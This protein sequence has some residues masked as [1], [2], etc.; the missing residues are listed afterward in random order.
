MEKNLFELLICAAK[1][2]PER[3]AYAA[4]ELTLT[5]RDLYEK[6]LSAAARI[7]GDAAVGKAVAIVMDARSAL[8][9]PV[10]MGT[11]AAGC[12]Y[13]PLDPALPEER[14][15]LI[16]E[17]LEPAVVIAD[18]KAIDKVRAAAPAA[19]VFSSADALSHSF[20]EEAILTRCAAVQPDD[21]SMVLYTSGSTGIPKGVAHTHGAMIRWT[22]ATIRKY[23][24]TPD[25]VLANQSPFYYA[26]SLLELFVPMRLAARVV[27][28][29]PSYLSFPARFV[30]YLL[31]QHVTELCMTPSSFV[32]IANSGA[33]SDGLFEEMR[34]FIMSGEVMPAVQL[35]QWMNAA[36]KAHAMN[37]Y[38]ST[39]ALSV[40]VDPVIT[41]EPG[42]VIP[43]GRLLP[44]VLMRLM[45]DNGVSVGPD[46][47]GEMYVHSDRMSVGYYRDAERTAASFVPDPLGEVEGIWFRTGDLG[48][49][50][51]EGCLRVIG[52][53]DSMFKH[54]GYRM[55]LGEVEAAVRAVPGCREGCCFYKKEKDEIW[56][57]AC[58]D[59]TRESLL[60]ELKTR[61][62]RYMLPEKIV[63]LPEMP[64]T[65]RMKIDR[66]VLLE[67]MNAAE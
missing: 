13:A 62:A 33:L 16:F 39:E 47:V 24:L 9:V 5:Y 58:G 26:N 52:R 17:N 12:F 63:I 21:L 7:A 66:Q 44:G 50:S 32:A 31:E 20:D 15:R 23:Q 37:F 67:Q 2:N 55:E 36:P 41:A 48:M 25:D 53:K 29:P 65:D 11:L 19:A 34:L 40:A 28:V 6:S 22:D 59:I 43:V 46:E 60:T 61:L 18:D 1:T 56:C 4:P 27:M 8:M 30:R 57:F 3:A 54:H 10:M 64:H 51:A 45:D 42:S 14:L 38:G 35:Q 49:M